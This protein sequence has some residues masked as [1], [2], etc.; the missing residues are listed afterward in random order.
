MLRVVLA[1]GVATC[2]CGCT[3]A[4]KMRNVQTGQIAQCGPYQMA[5]NAN[6]QAER[7]EQCVKDFQR[8]GYERLP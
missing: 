6:V 8:Q 2:L 5:A 3:D 4:I 7:E 1:A